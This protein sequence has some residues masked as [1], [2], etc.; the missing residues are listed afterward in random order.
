[1]PSKVPFSDP[2]SNVK[3]PVIGNVAPVVPE[4]KVKVKLF[5]ALV[6]ISI[7]AIEFG[8][9][10]DNAGNFEGLLVTPKRTILV[11][12]PLVAFCPG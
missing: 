5:P 3:L 11:L 8:R 6:P 1:M 10:E 9:V 7:E 4:P 2:A 12:L